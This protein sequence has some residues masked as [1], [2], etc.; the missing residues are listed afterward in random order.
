MRE[1]CPLKQTKKLSRSQRIALQKLGVE[2][3]GLRYQSEKGSVVIFVRDNGE[4]V[5]VDKKDY[6][7]VK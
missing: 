1:V 6:Y 5:T 2:P 3:E 4:V 7:S